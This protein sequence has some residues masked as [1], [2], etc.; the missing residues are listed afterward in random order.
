MSAD[1]KE[2]RIIPYLP[3]D[4]SE[5]ADLVSAIRARRGGDLLELDRMLL[6]SVPLARGWNAYLREIRQNLSVHAQLRELAILGVA[7][8]NRAEYEF[9]QHAPEYL[10]AGGKPEQLEA[11]RSLG[12]QHFMQSAFSPLERVV[13]DLTL[14]MTRHIEVPSGIM[15]K[16]REA[17]GETATVELV[18]VVATYNMVSRFL[19]ALRVHP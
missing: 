18:A 2:Q 10:K 3:P 19:V 17:L 1:A 4:L 12:E 6:H 11:V 9:A 13:C 16:L 5:P 7:V 8:L 15:F 14:A